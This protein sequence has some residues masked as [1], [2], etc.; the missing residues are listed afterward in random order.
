MTAP[1]APSAAAPARARRRGRPARRRRSA[2]P[3]SPRSAPPRRTSRSSATPAT[4]SSPTKH[5]RPGHRRPD[6]DEPPQGHHDQAL[7]LRPGVPRGPARARRATSS[8]G[9]APGTPSV[10]GHQEDQ[11]LHDPAAR[12]RGAAVQRQDA[13]R[14]RC[15]STSWTRAARR[16]ATCASATRSCRSR[17]G[18]SPRDATP[19]SSVTVVFPEGFEVEVEA[20][21]H[22]GAHDR[23]DRADDLPDRPAR[24]AADVLRVP[25]RRPARAP[26]P[27]RTVKPTVARRRRSPLTIRSWPDDAAWAKRVGGLRRAR[28]CRSSASGSGCPGR[29]TDAARRPGGGQPLDRRLRRAVRP[30]G[31]P[32]RGRLLRRR[33]RRPPRGGARLV[34][35]RAAGRSLGERGVRLVLRAEAAARRSRSRRPATS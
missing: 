4:T 17:S 10:R 20:G 23:R 27:T 21:D 29:A 3:A 32:R 18:R 15:A 1:C 8:P 24:Q 34:Q 22:P 2:P 33:L 14:T 19:G 5:A 25:R 31:G 12:P 11:G 30:D 26:T 35:R 16:P 13:R 6:A 7:L 28:R 9:P